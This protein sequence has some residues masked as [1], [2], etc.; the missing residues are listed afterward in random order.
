MVNAAR[1]LADGDASLGAKVG[2]VALAGVGILGPG[3]GYTTIGDN[4]RK[5]GTVATGRLRGTLRV[6]TDLTGGMD[7]ARSV[8]RNLTGKNPSGSF[9]RVVLDDGRE[10]LFRGTSRTKSPKVEVV[11]PDAQVLEKITFQ[12]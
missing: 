1:T 9:D 7:A 4:L 8:F 3:G 2:T 12:D 11:D 5:A 6:N 10:V